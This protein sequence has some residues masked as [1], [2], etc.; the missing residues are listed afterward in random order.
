[1]V[2]PA[3]A[4]EGP[5]LVT[6]KSAEVLTVVVVVDVLLAELGSG[7]A[8]LTVAALLIC[9]PVGT[10]ALIATVMV[11]VSVWPFG[12]VA[13]VSL[14]ML[15]LLLRLNTSEPAIW[16]CD[17]SVSPVGSVSVSVTFWASLGPLF[18]TVMV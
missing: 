13:M 9:G 2:V 18:V 15:P 10:L 17:T 14:I 1:M 11:K 5:V 6:A 3:G 16:L 8:L 7:V 4:T 12:N